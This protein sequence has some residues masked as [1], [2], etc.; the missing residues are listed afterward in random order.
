MLKPL[1]AL[2]FITL[3]SFAFA[4]CEITKD[5][6]T[7]TLTEVE[8]EHP[9]GTAFKAF[10]LDAEDDFEVA[11]VDG[12]ACVIVR[13]LQVDPADAETEA[14]LRKSLGQTVS[15]TSPDMF[16]AHTAW[17]VGDAVAMQA[18]LVTP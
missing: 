1:F 5:T 10:I 6:I 11:D 16:Q 13:Y 17:H 15:V 14:A 12:S 3:P 9:N 8:A 4:I 2:L 7:G 18:R